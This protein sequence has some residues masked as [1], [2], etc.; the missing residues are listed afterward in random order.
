MATGLKYSKLLGPIDLQEWDRLDAFEAALSDVLYFDLRRKG[1]IGFKSYSNK[2]II[3][4]WTG[5]LCEFKNVEGSI[6]IVARTTIGAGMPAFLATAA[7]G[8]IP[9]LVLLV[10]IWGVSAYTSLLML[11]INLRTGVGDKRAC[12]YR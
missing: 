8:I 4:H 7:L 9:A 5:L 1:F 3:N 12:H 6:A 2:I 11:E 10:V